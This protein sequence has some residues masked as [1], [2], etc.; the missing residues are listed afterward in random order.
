MKEQ[1]GIVTAVLSILASVAAPILWVGGVREVNVRQDEKIVQLEKVA[2]I[3]ARDHDLI[4]R[5]GEKLGVNE[6]VATSNN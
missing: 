1:L 3:V 6:G 2:E 5:I 4:V